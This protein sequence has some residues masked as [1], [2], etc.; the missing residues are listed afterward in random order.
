MYMHE[1]HIT[2]RFKEDCHVESTPKSITNLAHVNGALGITTGR[3]RR[4]YGRSEQRRVK[5]SKSWGRAD[6]AGCSVSEYRQGEEQ[7]LQSVVGKDEPHRLCICVK[8]GENPWHSHK[9]EGR[10]ITHSSALF[11][12]ITMGRRSLMAR[13]RRNQYNNED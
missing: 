8:I 6:H 9:E 7:T 13:R 10:E 4:L 2:T 1:M 3:Q 11:S 5:A 12:V